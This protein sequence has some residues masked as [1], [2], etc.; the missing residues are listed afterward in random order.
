M[1][2]G[3]PYID[4]GDHVDDAR[5]HIDDVGVVENLVWDAQVQLAWEEGG[6]AAV[7]L[8]TDLDEAVDRADSTAASFV[9]LRDNRL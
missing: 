9:G 2:A 1:L 5:L 8:A 6:A 7:I 4:R 3:M